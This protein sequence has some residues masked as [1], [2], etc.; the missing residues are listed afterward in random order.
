MPR[1]VR[2][3]AGA[4]TDSAGSSQNHFLAAKIDIRGSQTV[5]EAPRSS[6]SSKNR[7][8]VGFKEPER[9]WGRATGTTGESMYPPLIGIF[10]DQN[11]Q[12]STRTRVLGSGH[13]TQGRPA[14]PSRKSAVA[15]IDYNIDY[16]IDIDIG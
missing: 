11:H 14:T 3:Q 10:Q 16:N 8:S 4:Q 7:F 2:P 5:L 1:R 9:G 13:R 15:D 12:P 6:K